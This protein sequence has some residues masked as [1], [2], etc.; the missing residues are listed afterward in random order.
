M[1][2][3]G[4]RTPQKTAG[5]KVRGMHSPGGVRSC[6]E[7]SGEVIDAGEELV[8]TSCGVVSSKEVVETRRSGPP[9]AIDFTGQGLGGYLGSAEPTPEER[10]S[11][12]LAGSHSSYRYLKLMSDYAGREDSTLYSCAKTIERVCDQLGLPRMVMGQSVI[13]AKK[14]LCAR[15][16]SKVSSAAVS[17]FAIITACKMGETSTVGSREVVEMHR[18]LG[19]RVSISDLIRLSLNAPFR[20][21]PRRPQDYLTKVVVRLSSDQSVAERLKA[22]GANGVVYFGKLRD[23]AGVI[24]AAIDEPTK[25][26]HHPCALAATAV[27]TAEAR[28]SKTEGRRPRFSQRDAARSAGVAEYTVREQFR[29]IFKPTPSPA[30]MAAASPPLP[31][32]R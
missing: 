11:T 29:R 27:Y 31:L 12:G 23:D 32:S 17:A 24:L 18:A 3:R 8:C 14:T 28:L 13:I 26:G 9:Q 6:V 22:E 4:C 10:R 21:P 2:G 7:C 1:K 16:D 30:L 5:A 15:S 19:R 20:L 25:A